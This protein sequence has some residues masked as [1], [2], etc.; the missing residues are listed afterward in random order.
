[1]A[2]AENLLIFVGISIILAASLNIALGYAGIF[3]VAHGAFYGFGAYTASLI[4]IHFTS[5]FVVTALVAA[6]VSGILAILLAVPALR[7]REE[8]FIIA[9]MGFQAVAYTV[10]NNLNSVTG[11]PAGLTGVP[12]AKIFGFAITS[13]WGY[14]ALTMVCVVL[15]LFILWL[16]IRS[17]L[18]RELKALRDDDIAAQSLGKSPVWGR[19]VATVLAGAFAGIAGAIFSAYVSFVNPDSFTV[20]QSVLI[21]AMVI[22]GG[23]GTL[24]GPVIGAAF[25]TA[26][27]PIISL[28]GFIPDQYKGPVQQIIFGAA[29]IILMRYRPDGLVGIGKGFI[30]LFGKR[31]D[32]APR[33]Y[34]ESTDTEG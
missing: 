21:Q 9:S 4:A 7:V 18:G 30:S 2:Y 1:M 27:P 10:F 32:T 6:I 13:N 17:P 16:L 24:L 3:S 23:A 11:G 22:I 26:V 33:E 19:V 31:T 15:V 8:Y 20:D 12:P 25:L 34:Q 28:V 29:M 5:E 14:L